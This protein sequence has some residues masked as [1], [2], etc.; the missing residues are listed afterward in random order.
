MSRYR[1]RHRM[2]PDRT[3][4]VGSY[5]I[6]LSLVV[7]TLCWATMLGVPRAGPALIVVGWCLYP[8]AVRATS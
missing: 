4:L 6:V 3:R 2:R 8:V 1:P 7:L 5:V